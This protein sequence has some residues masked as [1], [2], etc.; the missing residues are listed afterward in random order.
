MPDTKRQIDWLRRRWLGVFLWLVFVISSVAMV[1]ASDDPV[2]IS[3]R[4]TMWESWLSQ[5]PT[6][7]QII[8]D[9]TSGINVSC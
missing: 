2:I 7:N 6:G 8:F 1:K 4:G 9:S 3:L 5:F